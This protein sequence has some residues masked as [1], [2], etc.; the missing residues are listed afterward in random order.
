MITIID[1]VATGAVA[2]VIA[3]ALSVVMVVAMVVVVCRGANCVCEGTPARGL[4]AHHYCRSWV[5][6]SGRSTRPKGHSH[7]LSTCHV[8][9][10]PVNR[11]DTYTIVA[12][13]D[14]IAH[15]A[16]KV[17]QHDNLN[18]SLGALSMI[19]VICAHVDGIHTQTPNRLR[20]LVMQIQESD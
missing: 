3:V 16:E 11:V 7:L 13:R 19:C 6:C 5:S 17:A 15:W 4:I 18:G 2:V 12:V 10:D 20:S 9:P 8:L 14:D 1:V